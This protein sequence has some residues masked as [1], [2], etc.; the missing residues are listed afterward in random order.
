M[1]AMLLNGW[2]VEESECVEEVGGVRWGGGYVGLRME[3][4]GRDGETIVLDMRWGPE[5]DASDSGSR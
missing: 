5:S 2:E 3:V 1:L 4:E